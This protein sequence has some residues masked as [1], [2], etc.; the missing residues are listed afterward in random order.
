MA[1][2]S[3]IPSPPPQGSKPSPQPYDLEP[4]VSQTP[5]APGSVPKPADPSQAEAP[6]KLAAKG[7][8]EGF[9]ED[10]DFDKDPEVEKA[11]G[12][13]SKGSPA[14]E[15]PTPDAF[16][17][18]GLGNAQVWGLVGGFLLIGAVVAAA[19]NTQGNRF[20]TCLLVLYTGIVHTG[21]GL[22]AVYLTSRLLS[23]PVGQLELAGGRMLTAVG[24][25]L[26]IFNLNINL[27][28][29]TKWEELV[30]AAA[31]YAGIIAGL[32]RLWGQRLG[33][34]VLS[35]VLLWM[36]FALGMELTSWANMAAPVAGA[37]P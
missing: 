9:D 18:P 33:M 27:I 7:V 32:F 34:L 10:A 13:S 35:H 19:M 14:A 12:K 8:L 22:V 29:T 21:T 11:L 4:A 28:G 6:G 23:K 25:F 16:V 5:A 24:A 26:L 30:L 17:Q 36:V 2:M 15:A 31:A 3:E 20:A 37:K 1:E